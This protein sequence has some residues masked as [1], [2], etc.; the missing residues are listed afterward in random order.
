[1]S[2]YNKNIEARIED[3][4]NIMVNVNDVPQWNR[5]AT[6][7]YDVDFIHEYY[8]RISDNSIT[9]ADIMNIQD[10]YVSMEIGIPRGPDGELENA[11]VKKRALDVDGIPIGKA[12]KNPVL[13]TREYE[14]EYDDGTKEI[15][16]ANVLAECILS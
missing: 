15:L 5:P 3:V 8:V 4:N 2:H 13:D 14:V 12:N 1:M 9:D 6:D 16:S 11:T 10:E 7:E